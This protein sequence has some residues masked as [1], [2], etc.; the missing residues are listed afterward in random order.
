[1]SIDN[2]L[3]SY[4]VRVQE[5]KDSDTD[6]GASVGGSVGGGVVCIDHVAEVVMVAARVPEE[7]CCW[8]HVRSTHHALNAFFSDASFRRNG[9]CIPVAL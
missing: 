7:Q 8:R 1:V 4:I 3:I 6:D 2:P 9:A 5:G